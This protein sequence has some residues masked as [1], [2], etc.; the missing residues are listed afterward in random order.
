MGEE[1]RASEKVDYGIQYH[2]VRILV[3]EPAG[4]TLF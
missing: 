1:E 3:R 4:T 2:T